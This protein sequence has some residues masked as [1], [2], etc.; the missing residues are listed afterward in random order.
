MKPC[1]YELDL[2]TDVWFYD[3]GKSAPQALPALTSSE[4]THRVIDI[5][6]FAG[7]GHEEALFWLSG[8]DEDGFV[9]LYDGFKKSARFA[10]S[11]H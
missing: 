11:Y 3:D 9:L 8:Y 4:A 6:D 2:V 5:G 10:W 7:D 1:E